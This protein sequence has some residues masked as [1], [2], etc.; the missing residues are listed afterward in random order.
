MGESAAAIAGQLLLMTS[1]LKEVQIFPHVRVDGDC[2]G[3]S[4]AMAMALKLLGIRARIYMDEPIPE[5]LEFVGIEPALL[6]IFDQNRLDEY[7]GQQ[8]IAMAVDCSEAARMGRSGSLFA[9]ASAS[10][11]IDHHISSGLSA[12]LRYVD[13][14]AAAAAEL[15]LEIIHVLERMTGKKLLDADV[16]NCLMV[17]L[18]SDTGRFSYQNTTP[19]TFRAAAELLENGAN[20]YINA[21]N[22]YD[23]TNVERMR[24]TS[25][26]LS[27]AKFYFGGRLALT[28]V[29]QDMIRECKAS[30]DASDGLAASLRDIKGVI[31]AFAVRETADGEIR[32]NIRSHDPFDSAA[33]AA[34]FNG[35]GHHRAAGFSIL[36]MSILE[37]SKL[38]IEKAGEV[39]S[40]NA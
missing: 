29:T 17:G 5:R 16:S 21:Y 3:S 12:G 2:L 39:I 22:L 26:A 23:V 18:Q 1:S 30:E 13:P 8:G 25:L 31:V 9:H 6:E 14:K 35:G 33:F 36:D 10:L 15:V 28:L 20:V 24:L 11:V 32:V 7:I 19:K 34:G 40:E 38:I 27:S 4:A 37:V